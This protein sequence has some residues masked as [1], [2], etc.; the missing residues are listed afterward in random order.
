MVSPG[1]PS[2]LSLKYFIRKAQVIKLYRDFLRQTAR[3]KIVTNQNQNH[4][5]EKKEK[6][7]VNLDKMGQNDLHGNIEEEIKRQFR[8]NRHLSE[9]VVA[10]VLS[11]AK[12]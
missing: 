6:V 3:L 2:Y 1:P 9:D 11:E 12:R 10:S 8:L 7:N 5:D 4:V